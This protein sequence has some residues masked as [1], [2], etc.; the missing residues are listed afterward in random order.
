VH[1]TAR[2]ARPAAAASVN[3]LQTFKQAPQSAA[4]DPPPWSSA[5]KTPPPRGVEAARVVPAALSPHRARN[6]RGGGSVCGD[7]RLTGTLAP[8]VVGMGRCGV[9]NPVRLDSAA[10]VALTRPV[11]VGCKVAQR[12]ADWIEADVHPAAREALGARLVAI[13]PFAGYSCRPRNNRPGARLSQHGLGK[14]IDVGAFRFDDGREVTV[15]DHWRTGDGRA[16]FLRA[17][18]RGACRHFGTVLGPQADRHHHDHIH[19]DVAEGREPYC[20]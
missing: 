12:L 5:M 3:D 4:G 2:T 1:P 16:A 6:L 19:V 11:T 10:G 8:T 15:K 14:A 9:D 7:A 20:R 18:W 17:A 13:E